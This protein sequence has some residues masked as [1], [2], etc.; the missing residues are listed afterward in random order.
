MPL[1]IPKYYVNEIARG[2]FSVVW[3]DW[4]I[5]AACFW[6]CMSAAELVRRRG[7]VYELGGAR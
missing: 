2:H 5:V 4:F 7:C 3:F 1:H 6:F